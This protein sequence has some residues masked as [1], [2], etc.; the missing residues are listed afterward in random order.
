MRA[1]LSSDIGWPSSPRPGVSRTRQGR[2]PENGAKFFSTFEIS[3]SE[4]MWAG[5]RANS[6]P[7]VGDT[8]PRGRSPS[9]GRPLP[10]ELSGGTVLS[11]LERKTAVDEV[12]PT[13]SLRLRYHCLLLMFSA[14]HG[15]VLDSDWLWGRAPRSRRRRSFAR[16]SLRL[17]S[18]IRAR[19]RTLMLPIVVRPVSDAPHT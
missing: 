19:L 10:C 17:R 18:S 1:W 11:S 3:S 9:F 12:V 6:I 8:E 2:T 5:S 15:R 13:C 16:R 14:S 7:E 4:A